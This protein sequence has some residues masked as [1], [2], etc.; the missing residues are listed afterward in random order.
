MTLRLS[1]A[2]FAVLY[3]AASKGS[4]WKSGSRANNRLIQATDVFDVVAWSAD[5]ILFRH[6]Q[7]WGINASNMRVEPLSKVGV[8][9]CVGVGRA[10]RGSARVASG[11]Q[12]PGADML[13]C[14]VHAH[15]H[16]TA[17]F[18]QPWLIGIVCLPTLSLGSLGS[19]THA[20][21][22]SAVA[23]APP[24]YNSKYANC[25]TAATLH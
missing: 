5:G 4:A 15:V 25:H 18:S 16:G 3:Y 17:T 2:D 1:V 22:P 7:G 9:G 24:K 19:L 8:V 14:V 21:V 10:G 23:S 11:E 6:Y 20:S 12:R 13:S